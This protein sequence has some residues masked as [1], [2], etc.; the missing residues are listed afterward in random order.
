MVP[1]KTSNPRTTRVSRATLITGGGGQLGIEIVHQLDSDT[2]LAPAHAQLDVTNPDAVD[3]FVEV[4]S[5][6][7][8]IHAAAITGVDRCEE[9]RANAYRTNVVGTWNVARAAAR[10]G[11]EMV[12]VSTNY[13]FDG[14]KLGPYFEY[15]TPNPLSTYGLTKL[16]GERASRQVLARLYIV[17]T[18]WLYSKWRKN[19]VTTLLDA[20]KEGGELRYVGDQVSNPTYAKD[21]AAA[22]VRLTETGAYGVHHLV[23]EGATSWYGWATAVLRT[24]RDHA[25]TL[26]E[27]TADEFERAATIPSNSEL[28]N[29]TARSVGVTLRPWSDALGEFV[30]ELDR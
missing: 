26:E 29:E 10:V 27:I 14:H 12:Y 30:R 22:I 4:N 28:A 25:V 1:A 13:V 23:N 9:A 24:L 15:D 6:D 3:R 18:S 11:A 7:L 5:P 20:A 16:F 19:F 21:L 8:I 17:R 2:V